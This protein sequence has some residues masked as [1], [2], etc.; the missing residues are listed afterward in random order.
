MVGNTR[1][2]SETLGNT[3]N[4]SEP[5]GSARKLWGRVKYWRPALIVL[6]VWPE[7]NC[8]TGITRVF[9]NRSHPRHHHSRGHISSSVLR[10][11]SILLP[12]PPVPRN[13][14]LSSYTSCTLESSEFHCF[15]APVFSSRH[16]AESS[17]APALLVPG[18]SSARLPGS[19][20]AMLASG[21]PIYASEP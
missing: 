21:L 7:R 1:K 10:S 3:R 4:R 19:S 2:H 12:Y 8:R 5:L 17:P 6:Q 14:S 13:S 9:V 15:P 11:Q 20:T 16:L 18:S